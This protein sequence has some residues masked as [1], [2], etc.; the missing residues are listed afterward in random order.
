MKRDYDTGV[1]NGVD[2]F[3]GTEVENTPYKGLRT[4]FIA[5][6]LVPEIMSKVETLVKEH[7]IEH[8]YFGANHSLRYTTSEHI[9]LFAAKF[10]EMPKTFDVHYGVTSLE[11]IDFLAGYLNTNVTMSVALPNV[12]KWENLSIKIDDSDFRASNPGVWVFQIDDL[13]KDTFND[14]EVYGTD[15]I[16]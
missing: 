1:A 7:D 8:I 6:P 9:A 2:Y 15:K 13:P 3:I 11:D 10:A 16:L 4:L 5:V 12:S 14:W